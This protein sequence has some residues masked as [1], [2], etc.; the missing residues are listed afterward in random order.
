MEFEG[1][2]YTSGTLINAE[3][4][5]PVWQ[6]RKKEVVM[7]RDV[8]RKKAKLTTPPTLEELNYLLIEQSLLHP[9][10]KEVTK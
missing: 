10:E 3:E 2:T 7:E 4:R 5:V 6:I 8:T 9:L 1:V